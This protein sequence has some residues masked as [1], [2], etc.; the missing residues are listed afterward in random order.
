[1]EAGVATAPRQQRFL[2]RREA[3][4]RRVLGAGLA[5]FAQQ[6]FHETS[7]E[8]VVAEA[9]TSK[10]TFYEFFQSKEDCFRELLEQ[11]GGALMHAVVDAARQGSD[12]RER[13]R[14]GITAFVELCAGRAPLA[15]LFLVESVGLSP[16]IE[17]VRHR[18]HA[19]FAELVEEEV[20]RARD[21]DRL[22]ADADAQVF[23]R[24]LIGAVNEATIHFLS[25]AGNDPAA[26]SRELCR[27]FAP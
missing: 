17:D 16:R 11:E 3:R 9:R 21:E 24:A 7:V 8:D 27:I 12:A 23:G 26:V 14:R 2:A 13:L 6:G 20:T 1:M 4:R 19:R 10:S 15:R 5:R 18:L 25:R 22:Y